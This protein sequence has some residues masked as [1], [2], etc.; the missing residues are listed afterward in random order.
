MIGESSGVATLLNN[1]RVYKEALVE[2]E[3]PA[4]AA[5]EESADK[6]VSEVVQFS[7]EAIALSKEVVAVGEGSEQDATQPE[8]RG[9]E[10]VRTNEQ[11]SFFEA[12]A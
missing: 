10:P 5:R 7:A 1:E 2:N 8:G 11:L 3:Q 12:V 6:V 4:V 9:Q